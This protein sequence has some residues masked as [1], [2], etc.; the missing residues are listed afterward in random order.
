M[1]IKG[2]NGTAQTF[3]TWI[4]YLKEDGYSIYLVG[5]QSN[6]FE[7][8]KGYCDKQIIIKQTRFNPSFKRLK[9]LVNLIT[10]H[11]IDIIWGVG[12][13]TTLITSIAG[14]IKSKHYLNILNMT[15]KEVWPPS[16]KWKYP[17]VGN[18]ITV[19]NAFKKLLI[20]ESNITSHHCHFIPE[21]FDLNI[22]KPAVK[23]FNDIAKKD[24]I[25][26]SIFSRF[27]KGKIDG[28]IKILQIFSNWKEKLN[29]YEINLYGGGDSEENLLHVVKKMQAI[30]LNIN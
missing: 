7:W 13:K 1:P 25:N 29:N 16:K 23:R 5:L 27:D 11:D 28:V 9:L 17:D 26:I 24:K 12:M 30:G 6:I 3:R 19:S 10:I 20:S 18:I 8:T 22:L 14:I 21:Q 4:K 2:L 15:R